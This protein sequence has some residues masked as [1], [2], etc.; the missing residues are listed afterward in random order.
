MHEGEWGTRELNVAIERTLAT[1]QLARGMEQGRPIVVIRERAGIGVF[2]IDIGIVLRCNRCP[3][4]GGKR[5]GAARGKFKVPKSIDAHND[6]VS[7][8]FG[9]A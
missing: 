1:D 9:G 6:E 4:S 5:L 8:L 2:D 3:G 7:K